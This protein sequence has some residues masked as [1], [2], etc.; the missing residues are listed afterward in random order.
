VALPVRSWLPEQEIEPGAM[1]QIRNTALHP[2]A[3]EAIAIMPDCHVGYGVTIGCV[4]PSEGAVI[5]NAVGVDI[6]CGMSAINSGVRLDT[7]RF[8]R[9]FWRDWS[10]DVQRNIPTG[11][12]SNS[13]L[14]KL[15][16]LDRPLRATALQSV[17]RD[18]GMAQLGTLGGGNHFLEAQVDEEGIIWFMVHSGSRHTGLRIAN[19]YHQLAVEITA[20]RGLNVGKELSSLPLDVQAGQ[21]YLHDMTWATDFALESRL[22]MVRG[23]AGA[24]S[25]KI[26]R[27]GLAFDAS[28]MEVIDIHHNFANI[29]S[30]GG[31][32][33]VIHR[34]GATSAEEDQIG[35]IPG[36][37]G[38]P[39][40]IVRGLGNELSFNSCSHGAG[41]KMG[42]KRAKESI[43][44]S[45]FEKSIQGTFSKASMSYVD[46]AP[47]AYKDVEN[48]IQ[49]QL[50]LI[51]VVHTLKPIITV[52]G[53]SRAKDD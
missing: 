22:R 43:T 45:D 29:E 34:K 18:K 40:Y 17:A 33:L 25:R 46:E 3:A 15:G 32:E 5:P 6:G 23:L 12:A 35:I 20:R 7:R 8:D 9:Q 30:H 13:R 44:S 28:E 53:D 2:E 21:D 24:F 38:S 51:E 48:V 50:D 39:S 42:R 41:R 11:F 10:G 19:E 36:S 14:A 1:E 47:G 4:M 31:R 49:R 37:M 16:D 52:K 26:E 27:L